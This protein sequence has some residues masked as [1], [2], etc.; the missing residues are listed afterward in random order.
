MPILVLSR[1]LRRQWHHNLV[2]TSLL[3]SDLVIAL[4]ATV[5]RMRSASLNGHWLHVDDTLW[6]RRTAIIVAT[7]I[8][9]TTAAARSERAAKTAAYVAGVTRETNGD[10]HGAE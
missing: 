4:V 1:G 6:R 3:I 5:M 9:A 7:V 2:F 8:A 10:A